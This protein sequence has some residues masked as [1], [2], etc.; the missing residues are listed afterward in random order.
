MALEYIIY[1]ITL[2]LIN[3]DLDNDQTAEMLEPL[4]VET[5]SM[6]TLKLAREHPIVHARLLGV[7]SIIPTE[8]YTDFP[9][10]SRVVNS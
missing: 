4:L 5:C 8:Q 2:F 10:N 6:L 7:F 1:F 3:T 9:V